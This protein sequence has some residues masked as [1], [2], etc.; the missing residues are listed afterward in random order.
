MKKI[1]FLLAGIMF[2]IGISACNKQESRLGTAWSADI[3][4]LAGASTNL[5]SLPSYAV[6][7]SSTTTDAGGTY[8]D[9]GFT[10]TQEVDTNGLSGV[11]MFVNA[12]GGT[13]TSTLWIRQQASFDGTNYFNIATTSNAFSATTTVSDLTMAWQWDPGTA[14]NTMARFFDTYG[15]KWTRWIMWGEN[16]ATD[17]NDEVQA[18]VTVARVKEPIR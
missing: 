14:T 8:K 13:A 17:P 11:S 5:V 2:L 18:W 3:V 7:D 6:F 10:I 15:Y 12:K 4:T 16:I 9:G 1:L